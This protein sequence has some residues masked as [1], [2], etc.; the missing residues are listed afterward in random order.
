MENTENEQPKVGLQHVQNVATIK[1][2]G[3]RIKYYIEGRIIKGKEPYRDVKDEIDMIGLRYDKQIRE[4]FANMELKEKFH[5]KFFDDNEFIRRITAI[6]NE[7]PLY[8]GC[9]FQWVHE[10]SKFKMYQKEYEDYVAE[11][12]THKSILNVVSEKGIE[13]KDGEQIEV[14]VKLD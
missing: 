12:E 6:I 13:L 2:E 14:E 3:D 11:A 7:N 5:E 1:K 8:I 10:F 9:F 4:L